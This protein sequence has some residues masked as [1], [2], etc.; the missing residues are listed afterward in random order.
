MAGS[1]A[2]AE[3]RRDAQGRYVKDTS[4]GR[5]TRGNKAPVTLRCDKDYPVLFTAL[6][7]LGFTSNIA[8]ARQLNCGEA[9]VS[10]MK[11]GE[12]GA[13]PEVIASAAV[14]FP[15]TNLNVFFDFNAGAER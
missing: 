13:G 11:H 3:R 8:K 1:T 2:T 10:R 4:T 5:P 9:T 6:D 14:M 12:Q 15:G 7:E